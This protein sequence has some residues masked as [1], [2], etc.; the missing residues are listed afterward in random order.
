MGPIDLIWHLLNLLA[1]PA[2]FGGVAAVGA[3]LAWRADL[4]RW[5]LHRLWLL[6]AGAA[7]AVAVMGLLVFGRDGRMAT[8][9]LMVV[10]VT[11]A[12]AWAILRRR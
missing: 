2:L 12:L 1:V 4:G 6:T 3:R 9:A 5:R 11:L 8:Y 10:A 7:A